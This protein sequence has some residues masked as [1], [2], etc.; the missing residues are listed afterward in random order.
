MSRAPGQN[1]TMY[2]ADAT[3]LR[4]KI[5]GSKTA[6]IMGVA[7]LLLIS[8]A[9]YEAHSFAL[10]PSLS[11]GDIMNH[12]HPFSS[13]S[14]VKRAG[15]RF[16]ERLEAP[17]TKATLSGAIRLPSIKRSL[18]TNRN[19]DNKNVTGGVRKT[20]SN[21]PGYQFFQ[22][23][24]AYIPSGISQEEYTRLRKEEAEVERKMDY[25]AWGPRFKRSGAPDGDWM[26]MPA[27]WTLGTVN[28]SRRSSGK[29]ARGGRSSAEGN[30]APRLVHRIARFLRA[31]VAGLL[32]AC[33]LVDAL[34]SAIV[35]YRVRDLTSKHFVIKVFNSVVRCQQQKPGIVLSSTLI[36][37]FGVKAAAAAALTP[38]VNLWI[39]RQNRRRLWTRL[40]SVSIAAVVTVVSLLVW[41]ALLVNVIR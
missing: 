29:A 1:A 17:T 40:K 27:L 26:V 2:R 15:L 25:G 38:F 5:N 21:V 12:P 6:K 23:D 8:K 19:S 34:L 32:L 31:N 13:R 11:T 4:R 22:G 7:L 37:S 3:N 10:F 36:K 18:G 30:Y 41:G 24:G 14:M 28:D 20:G 35:M 33:L 39:E 9:K 16:R